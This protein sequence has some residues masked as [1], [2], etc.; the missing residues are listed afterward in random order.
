LP[1]NVAYDPVTGAWYVG[2]TRKG[3]ILRVVGREVS[4]F[5]PAR[6]DSCGWSSE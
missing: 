1:E 6:A 5:R 3:K 4:E 2:S